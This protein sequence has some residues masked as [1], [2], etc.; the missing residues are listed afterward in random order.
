M[1]KETGTVQEERG[2]D[3]P[4]EKKRPHQPGLKEQEAAECQPD[5]PAN[6]RAVSSGGVLGLRA[7][8]ETSA[9]PKT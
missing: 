9:S 2:Q 3:Q 5:R 4:T 8:G 1:A 6:L 7:A